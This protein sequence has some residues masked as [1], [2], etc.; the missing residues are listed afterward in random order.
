MQEKEYFKYYNTISDVIRVLLIVV[1]I[2]TLIKL[3]RE[4]DTI[5]LL[6]SDV[7]KICMNKTGC[8]C[9]CLTP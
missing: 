3:S 8:Y 4:I 1:L 7:C 5:R 6:G 2:I 9:Y